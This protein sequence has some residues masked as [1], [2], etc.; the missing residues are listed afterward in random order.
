MQLHHHSPHTIWPEAWS[1]QCVSRKHRN[2][3]MSPSPTNGR[4]RARVAGAHAERGASGGSGRSGKRGS[5]NM[6]TARGVPW[7]CCRQRG[8]W[9]TI[10]CAAL[11]WK[12]KT[13]PPL[14]LYHQLG[15]RHL[16]DQ[17]GPHGRRGSGAHATAR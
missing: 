7:F 15:G 8:I 11:L 13:R 6:L 2:A 14:V 12:L 5:G 1:V 10:V 17:D 4:S 3:T 9:S 16:P